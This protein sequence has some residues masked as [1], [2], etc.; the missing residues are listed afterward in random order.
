MPNVERAAEELEPIVDRHG[1]AGVL[2]ALALVA[3]LKA[4]HITTNWNDRGLARSWKQ[5]ATR[6]ARLAKA[7]H[8]ERL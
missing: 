4:E 5:L 2:E 3:Q 8:Q 1:I 7:A 6:I